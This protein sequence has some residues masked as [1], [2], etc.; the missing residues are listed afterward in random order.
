MA[1]SLLDLYRLH[2]KSYGHAAAIYLFNKSNHSSDV[3]KL[4]FWGILEEEKLRRPDGARGGY[5]R[6]TDLGEQFI[7]GSV[8]VPEF[9]YV[10]NNRCLESGG[11]LVDI[12][13]CLPR[14]FD[15]AE[16]M[17]GRR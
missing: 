11:R 3:C 2:G 12:H 17:R 7:L 14:G 8:K 9:A 5:W 6:V 10:Y 16:V 13:E 4:R 1:V 15:Y